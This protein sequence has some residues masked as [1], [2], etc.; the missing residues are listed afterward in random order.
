MTNEKAIK[1]L[2]Q[3]KTYVTANSLDEVDYA[4]DV[5]KRLE[6]AGVSSPLEADFTKL[7]SQGSAK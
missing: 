2:E 5:L 3:I 4:I 6:K 1:A 7:T